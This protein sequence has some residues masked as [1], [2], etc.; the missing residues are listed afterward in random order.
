ME[1]LRRL[2][3]DG[4]SEC[5]CGHPSAV[6]WRSDEGQRM[7]CSAP[8]CNCSLEVVVEQVGRIRLEEGDGFRIIPPGARSRRS[9]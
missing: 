6:H 1:M 2:L 8:G 7:W 5:G 3:G 9:A 4:D